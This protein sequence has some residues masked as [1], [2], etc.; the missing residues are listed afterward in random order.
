MAM[1]PGARL[2]SLFRASQASWQA[3]ALR[4]VMKTLEAPDCRRLASA[5]SFLETKLRQSRDEKDTYPEAAWSPN[6]LEPPVT[7]ATLPSSLKIDGKLLSLTSCSACDM[8][9]KTWLATS[10]GQ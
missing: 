5:V 2:G 7:T 8:M 1:A 3:C 9:G 10:M 4:L 6:P